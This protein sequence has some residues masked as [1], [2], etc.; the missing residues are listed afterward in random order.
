MPVEFLR[1]EQAVCYGRY[2]ADPS[3]EQLALL[4]YLHPQNK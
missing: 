3:S 2:H 1:D 4:F